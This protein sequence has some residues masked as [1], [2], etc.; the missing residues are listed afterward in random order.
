MDSDHIMVTPDHNTADN[1]FGVSADTTTERFQLLSIWA[2]LFSDGK[3]DRF[4][5]YEEVKHARRDNEKSFLERYLVLYYDRHECFFDKIYYKRRMRFV[6]ESFLKEAN[7]RVAVG[8]LTGV[9][10]IPYSSVYVRP[11]GLG[12]GVWQV[13]LAQKQLLLDVYAEVLEQVPLPFLSDIEFLY[14]GGDHCGSARHGEMFPNS[15]AG[16]AISIFFTRNNP[17]DRIEQDGSTEKLLVAQYAWYVH[18]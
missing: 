18:Y 7:D 4:P 2:S 1:G 3:S 8:D 10:G 13:T 9:D 14:F 6:V 16:N 17:A 12:L 5:S 15:A 11:V